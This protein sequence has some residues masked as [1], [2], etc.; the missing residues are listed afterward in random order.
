MGFWV[1]SISIV[2]GLPTVTK[3]GLF[4]VSLIAAL[5]AW[6]LFYQTLM[7]LLGSTEKMPLVVMVCVI[8]LMAMAIGIGVLLP[9]FV[10]VGQGRRGG[11]ATSAKKTAEKAPAPAKGKDKAAKKPAAEEEAADSLAD[12]ED[13]GEA[14]DEDFE[15][16]DFEDDDER[17]K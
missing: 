4:A 2:W 17:K 8:L 7:A 14:A 12:N 15:F 3:K 16:E 10:L 11:A 6:F 1:P 5:P 13:F 9:G